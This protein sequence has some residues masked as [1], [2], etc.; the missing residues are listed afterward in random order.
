[1]NQDFIKVASGM[2]AL[3]ALLIVATHAQPF[4]DITKAVAGSTSQIITAL[5][6]NS[7]GG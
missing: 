6:G 4:G 2:G 3:I 5:Q 1:M 7:V